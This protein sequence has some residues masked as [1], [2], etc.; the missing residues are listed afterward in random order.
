MDLA[1][2]SLFPLS[3]RGLVALS[4]VEIGDRSKENP[5]SI[6]L[7]SNI[8]EFPS[9]YHNHLEQTATIFETRQLQGRTP[10]P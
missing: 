4:E 6:S 5:S 2:V 10:P 3:C 8:D 1:F 9:S 7:G